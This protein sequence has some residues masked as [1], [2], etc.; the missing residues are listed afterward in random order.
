MALSRDFTLSLCRRWLKKASECD[1]AKLEGAFDRFFSLFVAF[2]A[3]YVY[4]SPNDDRDRQQATKLFP[5]VVGSDSLAEALDGNGGSDDIRKLSELIG[6]GGGFFLHGKLGV[7]NRAHD[8]EV[9]RQLVSLDPTARVDAVLRFLYQLRCNLF[10]GRKD[11]AEEQRRVLVP[12]N[13][14][15]ERV[16]RVGLQ[17]IQNSPMT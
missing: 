9:G 14:C 17:H 7:P 13:R 8:E 2:N 6:P 5:K 3:V 12:A 11:M 4:L 15:L 1:G 10:H 16:V